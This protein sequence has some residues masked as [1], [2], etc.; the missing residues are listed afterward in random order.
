VENFEFFVLDGAKKLLMKNKPVV[1]A[2]LWDN[3][4]REKCFA[5]FNN[6]NYKTFV[7]L[8]NTLVEYNSAAHKKQNFIFL[9]Q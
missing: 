1:Y 8:D 4:N 7:V 2:E 6:L 3:E 9:P 5:L